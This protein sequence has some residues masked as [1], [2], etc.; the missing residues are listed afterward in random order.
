[1]AYEFTKA[2][3][4]LSVIVFDLPQVIEMRR[5]FQPKES[6]D[7]V[8]F[9]AGQWR[10]YMNIFMIENFTVYILSNVQKA[11]NLYSWIDWFFFSLNVFLFIC[12]IGDFFKDDL[13]KAD[14]YILARILHDWSDEK[15][16]VLLSKLSKMCTPGK[17]L[18]KWHY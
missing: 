13:P 7:S 18:K 14:L 2:H 8:S 6:D 5:H 12:M 17:C 10:L 3:P 9:V 11:L 4:G 15:L 1:M 16:H